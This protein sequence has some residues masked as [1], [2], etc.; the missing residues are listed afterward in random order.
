MNETVS[1]SRKLEPAPKPEP[2]N[3]EEK[4]DNDRHNNPCWICF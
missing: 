4:L 1:G 3:V 2:N